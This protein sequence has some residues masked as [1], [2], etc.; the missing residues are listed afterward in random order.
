MKIV[1][2]SC[3]GGF[4]LSIA[5]I[6]RYAEIKGIE[7]Y[8]FIN[9]NYTY[10]NCQSLTWAETLTST[11]TINIH[12]STKPIVDGK[13]EET[14]YWCYNN[15]KRDDEALVKVVEELG[16]LASGEYAKLTVVEIPDDV[17]WHIEE[18][19]GIETIAENHRKWG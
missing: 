4:G 9:T 19:D 7:L 17:E 2:N 8:P 1:I 3:F 18:Y 5:G 10:E 16:E 13:Y 14:S 12:F 11:Q 15:T 6:K